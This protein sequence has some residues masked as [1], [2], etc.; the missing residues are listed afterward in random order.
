MRDLDQAKFEAQER[1]F[2]SAIDTNPSVQALESRVD[3]VAR[4]SHLPRDRLRDQAF[5]LK[6]EKSRFEGRQMDVSS[7]GPRWIPDPAL[8]ET[9]CELPGHGSSTSRGEKWSDIF[10]G[11]ER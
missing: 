4:D 7:G 10:S 3:R 11:P 2:M 9:H 5:E 8:M 1:G 6:L